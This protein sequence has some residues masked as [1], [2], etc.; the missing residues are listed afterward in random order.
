LVTAFTLFP[1]MAVQPWS[2]ALGDSILLAES[3]KLT[4]YDASYLWLARRL[5][6]EL[7]TLDRDLL[8]AFRRSA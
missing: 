4:V 2:V 1:R 7:V 3:E 5:G 8:A 6:V